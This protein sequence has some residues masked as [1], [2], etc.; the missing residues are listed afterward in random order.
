M[1]INSIND[2]RP[3]ELLVLILMGIGVAFGV[4]IILRELMCW[5]YKINERIKLQKEANRLLKKLV[6]ETD[7]G[8]PV[9]WQ[10]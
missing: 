5:Y 4:F 1:L 7:T 8:L 2:M 10:N 9:L 3:E 6:G